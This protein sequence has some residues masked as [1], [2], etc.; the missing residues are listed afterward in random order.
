MRQEDPSNI[1]I[2]QILNSAQ[3]AAKLTQGLLTFSRKQ[4]IN[5][6]PVDINEIIKGV[7]SLLS[8]LIGD[9]IEF[10]TI[11]SEEELT[12]VADAIQIEQIL[13]NLVTNARDA[14]PAGG[15]LTVKTELVKFDSKFVK[16]HGYGKAGSYALITV[17]D[18]GQ[19]MDEKTK[20]RI[21]EP[22]FTTKEVGKGTGLGLSMVYGIVQQHNG[23]VLVYSDPGKGTAFKL[24]FPLFT[25]HSENV[26]SEA[27]T[28]SKK[29]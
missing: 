25:Q 13:M 2:T 15:G 9:D 11:L 24:Y 3:K 23:D 17:E 5:P 27:D 22:F 28:V 29:A 20:T 21:F 16:K 1:Y 19:G 4:I 12:V 10:S 14:M 7:E 26:N 18:T 8:R 6:V